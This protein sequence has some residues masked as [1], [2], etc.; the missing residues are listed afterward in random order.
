MLDVVYDEVAGVRIGG[1]TYLWAEAYVRSLRERKNKPAPGTLRK[2]A[3]ALAGALDWYFIG[4]QPKQPKGTPM[5]VDVLRLLSD[6]YSLYED[7]TVVDVQRDLCLGPGDEEKLQAAMNG[8]K[9]EDRERPWGND[10]AFTMLFDLIVDSGLRLRDAYWS[11]VSDLGGARG[12]L[13]V[14]GTKWHGG[15]AKPR[16]VPLKR[17]LREKLMA[18]CADKRP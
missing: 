11:R 13:R 7:N 9:R 5:P 17:A 2:R 1:V 14:N 16:V 12:I 3:S 6:G 10:L 8:V 18:W 15:A 4:E